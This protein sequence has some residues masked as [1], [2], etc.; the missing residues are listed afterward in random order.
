M[1]KG[2]YGK[3]IT[4]PR[5]YACHLF[6]SIWYCCVFATEDKKRVGGAAR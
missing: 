1:I 5:G 4:E 2:K 3:D 6:L